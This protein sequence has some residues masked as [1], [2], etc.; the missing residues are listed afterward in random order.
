[1]GSMTRP[2]TLNEFFDFYYT[3][4]KPL[5]AHLQT[6]S[7]P[8]IEMFFEG[9]AALDHLSRHWKYGESEEC[10]VSAAAAHLKRGCFDAFKIIVRGTGDHYKELRNIETGLIDNGDFDM[11][12]RA[13]MSDIRTEALA[14]R[15]AEGDSR[16]T[17]SWHKAY[18]LW[19]PVY[20]KC[21]QFDDDFYLN[22]NVEWA[23]GKTKKRVWINRV[24]GIILGIVAGLLTWLF[25][26]SD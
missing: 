18:D 23:R 14:A 16:D 13:L 5:Y 22:K 1:M 25:T 8:P 7:E 15:L 17:D 9:N 4:F 24:E 6:L 2:K 21:M 11:K 26:K 20:I 10:V 12:M 3:D 19:I